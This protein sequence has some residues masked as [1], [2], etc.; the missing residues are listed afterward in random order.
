MD[1]V[2][3]ID[4]VVAVDTVDAVVA[5]VYVTC[6]SEKCEVMSICSESWGFMSVWVLWI[7]WTLLLL[8]LLTCT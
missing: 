1:T 8:L 6:H 7:L 5:H 2:V 4:T 3:A